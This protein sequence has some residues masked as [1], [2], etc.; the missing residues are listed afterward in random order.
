[1]GASCSVYPVVVPGYPRPFY[2][3]TTRV[4]GLRSGTPRSPSTPSRGGSRGEDLRWSVAMGDNVFVVGSP[5]T[6]LS[7]PRATGTGAKG[8]GWD[9][10]VF[11]PSHLEWR[12]R[13]KEGTTSGDP[14]TTP[15]QT[16]QSLTVNP[17]GHPRQNDSSVPWVGP[18]HSGDGHVSLQTTSPHVTEVSLRTGLCSFLFSGVCRRRLLWRLCRCVLVE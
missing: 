7:L 6:P 17:S 13:G 15:G 1:M 18:D 3:P 5:S 11:G 9:T 4:V 16:T 14:G 2:L 8:D 10:P 12:V